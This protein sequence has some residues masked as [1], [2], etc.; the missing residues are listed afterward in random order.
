M[1]WENSRVLPICENSLRDLRYY[2]IFEST[3]GKHKRHRQIA[4]G[5]FFVIPGRDQSIQEAC[6]GSLRE[7]RR[8]LL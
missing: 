3:E 5:V 1:G 6:A 4:G 2:T 8:D 7:L